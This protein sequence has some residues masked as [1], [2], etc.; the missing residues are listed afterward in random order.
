M[1]RS[2]VAHLYLSRHLVGCV[3]LLM[4]KKVQGVANPVYII[5]IPWFIFHDDQP[6]LKKWWFGTPTNL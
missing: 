1:E 2:F 3:L 4:V 5:C 6:L